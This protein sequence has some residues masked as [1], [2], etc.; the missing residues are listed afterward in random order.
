MLH[1]FNC[2]GLKFE[3]PGKL[4]IRHT[5]RFLD[6][7]AENILRRRTAGVRDRLADRLDRAPTRRLHL[8]RRFALDA[9]NGFLQFKT[10]ARNLRRRQRRINRLQLA[11]RASIS[12]DLVQS[13]EQGRT[14]N[15]TLQTLLKLG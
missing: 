4:Y 11:E 10:L 1:I 14:A 8:G 5:Q 13:L 3:S 2:L 6:G 9:A 15:P 12:P 7:A